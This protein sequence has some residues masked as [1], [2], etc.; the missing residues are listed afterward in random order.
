MD[1][2]LKDE[3]KSKRKEG[4]IEAW[5]AVEV[6]AVKEDVAKGSLKN[7]VEK[8]SKA[9][10]VFVYEKK[11]SDVKE[12][13]K[14][15]KKIEKGFSQIAEVKLFVRSLF[16]L[17]SIVMLYAPSSIEIIG[18]KGMD[19]RIDEIQNIANTLAAVVHQ[20][21]SAGVGGVVIKPE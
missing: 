3:I 12:V 7:H 18:P 8:L 11:F 6:L 16:S 5:F 10:D 20:F 1:D 19:V 4:W 9:K 17:I 21:A 15:A 13:E 14:P 2:D